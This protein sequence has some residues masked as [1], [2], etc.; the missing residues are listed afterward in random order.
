MDQALGFTEQVMRR[1]FDM[2]R[3]MKRDDAGRT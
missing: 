3:E 2:V 1:F